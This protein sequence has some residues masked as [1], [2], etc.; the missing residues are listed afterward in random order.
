M[1][2]K[3]YYLFIMELEILSR[4]HGVV[5][6]GSVDTSFGPDNPILQNHL[7]YTDDVESGFIQ[8]IIEG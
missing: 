8:P 2:Q 6:R 7:Q 3:D 5:F 4:K 1:Q